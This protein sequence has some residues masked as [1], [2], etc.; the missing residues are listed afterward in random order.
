MTPAARMA[1]SVIISNVKGSSPDR[2]VK[3]A[4]QQLRVRRMLAKIP[5]GFF[6]CV[7]VLKFL[8]KQGQIFREELGA[9]AP[10]NDIGN[11]AKPGKRIRHRG[12]ILFADLEGTGAVVIGVHQKDGIHPG[13]GGML[14]GGKG[15]TGIVAA[16]SGNAD[17]FAP[18]GF[19]D[20]LDDAVVLVP[21]QGRAFPRGPHCQ[22]AADAV[23]H[24]KIG[25]PVQ[26]VIIDGTFDKR[27]DQSREASF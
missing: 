15:L 16:G 17:A 11:H 2:M 1:A 25:Q 27:S 5:C 10:R 14:G 12:H 9:G 20:F 13:L 8:I 21:V 19:C 7:D 4:P 23:F 26:P 24:L 6:D 18:A 22:N 3:D